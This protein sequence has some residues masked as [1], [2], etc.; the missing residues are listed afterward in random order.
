MHGTLDQA[1]PKK[2]IGGQCSNEKRHWRIV[3][4]RKKTLAGKARKM[5]MAKEMETGRKKEMAKEE[6]GRGKS[7]EMKIAEGRWKYRDK[8]MYS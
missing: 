1:A 2:D 7:G 6:E 3:Q 8:E 5:D 4:H